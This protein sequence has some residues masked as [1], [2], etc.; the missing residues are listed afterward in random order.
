MNLRHVCAAAALVLIIAGALRPTPR[1]TAQADHRALA[2]II[3]AATNIK[4][5]G[6][7]QLRQVYSGYI[8]EQDGTRLVPFNQA[9]GSPG[10]IQF[11]EL[12]LGLKPHEV[13]AFW[14]DQRIRRTI[15]PPRS[16]PSSD[17]MIRVV[18]SL[19]GAIGY[20]HTDPAALPMAVRAV[21]IDGVAPGTRGYPFAR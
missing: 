21:T 8:T 4:N 18:A 5:I 16:L 15:E 7:G 19:P 2:V 14:I 13:G 11:D 3:S 9:T 10:R 17:L 20:V 6:V 12:V 1:A